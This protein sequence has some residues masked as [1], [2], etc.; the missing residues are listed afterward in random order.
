MLD[1]AGD[2]W[3]SSVCLLINTD[4]K[5]VVH[6]DRGKPGAFDR[7]NKQENAKEVETIPCNLRTGEVPSEETTDAE[8]AAVVDQLRESGITPEC[9]ENRS[10][11]YEEKLS[12]EGNQDTGIPKTHFRVECAAYIRSGPGKKF[13]RG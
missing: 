2:Q 1:G 8:E 11:M 6:N 4:I 13:C 10:E 9:P 7:S 3:T 5:A 12:E